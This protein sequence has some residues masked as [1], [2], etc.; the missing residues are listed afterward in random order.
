[1]EWIPCERVQR[2]AWPNRL[3]F[4]GRLGLAVARV[5]DVA[6]PEPVR[7]WPAPE[8]D[9]ADAEQA[10]DVPEEPAEAAS[11]DDSS[12]GTEIP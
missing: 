6:V 2:V 3:N 7:A 4:P 10:S 12:I 8:L 1:M 9:E 5:R 11:A